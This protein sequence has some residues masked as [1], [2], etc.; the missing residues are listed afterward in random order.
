MKKRWLFCLVTCL[1]FILTACGERPDP[2]KVNSQKATPEVVLA[3]VRCNLTMGWDPWEPYQ[4]LSLDDEVKGLEVDLISAMANEAGCD[5]TFVQDS[6][7]N[8]L[9]GIRNGNIDMLGGA[10]KTNSR[11]KFARFSN[12]YR[13][14]SFLLYVRAGEPAEYADRSLKELLEDG[15]R[16]GITQDYIYGEQV[17]A[18]QDDENLSSKLV[19]VPITEVN[20]YNLTQGHIDGFLEDPFVAAFTIK[21]KGLQG[22]IEA[23]DI[24]IHSGDVSIIFSKESVT[25]ETV[26]A[27]NNALVKLEESGQYEKILARY[28][29]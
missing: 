12:S 23:L 21:R 28:R 20:Y 15:F 26:E 29:R 17:N 18:I 16:L 11:E 22:Q 5:I 8:L 24:E 14:E 9:A 7:M 3:P 27:F 6:W 19:S 2:N 13:H 25:Q 4:Y 1:V 10:T